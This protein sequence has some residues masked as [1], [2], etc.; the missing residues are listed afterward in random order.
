LV[1]EMVS[2]RGI[3]T[4]RREHPRRRS[5]DQV[6]DVVLADCR[7]AEPA[8][9][10]ADFAR[11][12][13]QQRQGGYEYRLVVHPVILGAGRPFFPALSD[14]IGLRLRETRK[15]ASGVVY[16]GYETVR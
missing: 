4:M 15:F 14:R 13:P 8:E 7:A 5:L 16:L 10:D 2:V 3:R 12:P 9:Q 1:V 6:V 11:Q